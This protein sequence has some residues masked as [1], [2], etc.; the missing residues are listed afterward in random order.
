M[1]TLLGQRLKRLRQEELGLSQ[2][3]IGAQGFVSSAGWI[4]VE[5]GQRRA[6]EKL[7]TSLCSFLARDWGTKGKRAEQRAAE[8]R[9]E[10]LLLKYLDDPS[11]FVRKAVEAWAQTTPLGQRV[12]GEVRT[13]A[14]EKAKRGRPRITKGLP[15]HLAKQLRKDGSK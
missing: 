2:E 12:L 9:D 7:R 6:S 8:L 1:S 13:Y 14:H 11:A 5:N 15:A 3:A 4:K 10:L